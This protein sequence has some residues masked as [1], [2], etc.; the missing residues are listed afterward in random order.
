[1][2]PNAG[3]FSTLY[4]QVFVTDRPTFKKTF[5]DLT[6]TRRITCLPR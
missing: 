4:D 1:M 5:Q 6:G 3:Q 2:R